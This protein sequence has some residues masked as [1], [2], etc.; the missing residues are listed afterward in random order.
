MG[1]QK[2]LELIADKYRR[3]GFDVIVHPSPS[4]VPSFLANTPI[5]L[6]A[7]KGSRIVA[8][9]ANE[10]ATAEDDQVELT[11]EF[12]SDSAMLLIEEAEMLLNPLTLRSA[13]VMA[14]SAFE[15]A[16]RTALQP[17]KTAFAG[18]P[19]RRTLE[20][21][22]AKELI[23][24]EEFN[25]LQQS[26]YN[27]NVIA[28][29]GRPEELPPELASSV[30]AIAKR[31]ITRA[32]VTSTVRLRDSVSVAVIRK[33]VNQS[34]YKDLVDRAS[35]VLT[36]LLGPL[37]DGVA[38]DWDLAEDARGCQILVLK[39]SDATGTVSATFD[40]SEL[41]DTNLL[42]SR[43]NR[44]WG[45][46]LEIRSHNQLKRLLGSATANSPIGAAV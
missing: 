33:G 20:E 11:A 21:L 5:D 13:L 1:D 34:K 24:L 7:R 17:G 18:S 35:Q 10:D 19:P 26:L 3:V 36:D 42:M 45:D 43:L 14:W 29:G 40:P 39:M 22:Q 41:E 25:I 15:A 12:G 16:A 2:I 46:L 28:H 6:L 4:D 9:K 38:I 32:G 31:L 30:L 37:R 23:S 27:R 8:F 44:L